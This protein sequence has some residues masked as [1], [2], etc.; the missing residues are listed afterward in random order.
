[1]GSKLLIIYL[2]SQGDMLCHNAKNE[3]DI[4][5]VSQREKSI[6]ASIKF[7]VLEVHHA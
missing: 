2:L 4:Q 7:E 6:Q 1:M 5:K 3:L